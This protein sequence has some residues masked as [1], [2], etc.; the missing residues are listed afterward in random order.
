M[1]EESK[2]VIEARIK[3]VIDARDDPKKA[4]LLGFR[5]GRT[6][7]QIADDFCTK[8][9]KELDKPGRASM[10]L[11]GDIMRQMVGDPDNKVFRERCV[12]H[13]IRIKRGNYTNVYTVSKFSV[14]EKELKKRGQAQDTGMQ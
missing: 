12:V 2:R 4:E 1:P 14:V 5:G 6:W 3:K 10:S 11:P 13:G 9:L 7:T 8:M